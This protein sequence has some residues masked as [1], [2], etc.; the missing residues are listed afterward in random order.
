MLS[1][2]SGLSWSSGS[3]NARCVIQVFQVFQVPQGCKGPAENLPWDPR[4]PWVSP[5]KQAPRDPKE[6]LVHPVPPG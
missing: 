2:V 4:D 3:V 1:V 5:D 6:S